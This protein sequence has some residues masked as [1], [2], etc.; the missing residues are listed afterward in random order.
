ML[1]PQTARLLTDV[2]DWHW[3]GAADQPC[4][5]AKFHSPTPLF[6]HDVRLLPVQWFIDASIVPSMAVPSAW[7][8]GTCKDNVALLQ[9]II[10]RNK[11]D[12]PWAV[13]R[14]FG[15]E[16]RR[17]AFSGWSVFLRVTEEARKQS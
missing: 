3:P 17:L 15:N 14:E 2:G 6:T 13:R 4:A 7:L 5:G 12:V 16:L 9:Q 1:P 11:G 10:Y 8:C